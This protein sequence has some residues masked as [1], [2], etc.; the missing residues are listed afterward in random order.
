MQDA[1]Q[2]LWVM[3]ADCVEHPGGCV[4]AARRMIFREPATSAIIMLLAIE[5]ALSKWSNLPDLIPK[6]FRW[7]IYLAAVT[8]VIWIAFYRD[9]TEFIY[10][11]F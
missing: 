10:F 11:Q 3:I 7:L 2:Y 4:V 1:C 8:V 6:P 5:L 9:A